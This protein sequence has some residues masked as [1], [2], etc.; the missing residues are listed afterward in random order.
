MLTAGLGA[1]LNFV[2]G[3]AKGIMAKSAHNKYANNLSGLE[4]EM[5]SAVKEAEGILKSNANANM[6]G[7]ADML[8]GVDSG[9]AKTMTQA[10]DISSSPTA[11]MDALIKSTTAGQQTKTQLGIQ[12]AQYRNAQDERLASFLS[13]VKAP[14]EQRINQFDIDKKLAVARERMVADKAL[15]EGIEGGIG[16]ALSGFGAGAQVDYT[17]AKTKDLE[18]FWED[19]NHG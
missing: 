7:Y 10:K 4:M 3:I 14:A 6:A 8:A 13:S 15:M 2:T 16:S 1:G 9:T 5:P 17:M 12:N 19:S 11:L 18:R